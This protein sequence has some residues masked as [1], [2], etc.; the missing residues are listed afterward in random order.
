MV[1]TPQGVKGTVLRG[2]DPA[3]AGQ[4]LSLQKDMV[5]GKL[6]DLDTAPMGHGLIVGQELA[7]SQ[8]SLP[9][10]TPL[11]QLGEQSVSLVALHPVGQ[12]PSAEAQELMLV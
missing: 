12:Q 11:P 6:V 10:S 9:S 3:T 5:Q 4:V 7:G 8:V 2:I 1:S